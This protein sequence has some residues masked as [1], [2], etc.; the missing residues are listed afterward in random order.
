MN[1]SSCN[2]RSKLWPSPPA[3]KSISNWARWATITQALGGS[4]T[5]YIDGNLFRIAGGDADPSAR[6]PQRR[7]R[8]RRER[9]KKISRTCVAAAE[10]LYD[11]EIPV[12]IV[13]LGLVY[14]CD[15]SKNEDATRTVDIKND[16]DGAGLRDG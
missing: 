15:V 6:L 1:R 5:V 10:D 16:F 13:D 2:A 12:N 7:P 3:S 11:P 9:R 14:V 8:C 4:F